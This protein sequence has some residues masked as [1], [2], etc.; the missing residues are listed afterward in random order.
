M[1]FDNF[2]EKNPRLTE[3]LRWIFV[4]PAAIIGALLAFGFIRLIHL[5]GGESNFAFFINEMISGIVFGGAFVYSAVYVAPRYKTK[6]AMVFAIL[7][8]FVTINSIYL[9]IINND[10]LSSIKDIFSCIGA[11]AVAVY[12]YYNKPIN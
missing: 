2:V 7:L 3:I 5:L 8:L 10:F 4:L 6:V 12:T 9:C 11:I 1:N